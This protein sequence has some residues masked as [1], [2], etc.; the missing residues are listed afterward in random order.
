MRKERK[1]N[2]RS[3]FGRIIDEWNNLDD[4]IKEHY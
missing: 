4:D 3:T 1:K 2:D